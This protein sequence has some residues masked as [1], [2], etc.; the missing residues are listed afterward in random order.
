MGTERGERVVNILA[1]RLDRRRDFPDFVPFSNFFLCVCVLGAVLWV[2][3]W[4]YGRYR[5]GLCRV[6]EAGGRGRGD[7]TEEEGEK[8]EKAKYTDVKEPC[9]W[10]LSFLGSAYAK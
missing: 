4:V 9:K 2:S 5:Q 8:Y 1:R 6:R 3:L 10:M 7:Q